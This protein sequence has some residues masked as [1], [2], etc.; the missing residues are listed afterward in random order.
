MSSEKKVLHLFEGFGI[1]LEYMIVNKES[2]QVLPIADKLIYDE[3]GAY[4]SD[5]EFG[6]IA[7]S[8]ELVQ[9]VVELKTQEP[10]NTLHDLA[11]QFQEHVQKINGMLGK[12]DAMLLPTGAHPFMDP[13]TETVL[14]QHEY[15]AVYEAYNNLFDCRGH[16]WSNLQST[17]INLP[18]AND[19]EFAR[20]HAAIRLVLP[21]IPA[22]SASSP[23]L[24]G[25][26]TGLEDT[27]IEVYRHNQQ[28]IPSIA[29]KVIPEPVTSR[30]QYEA[31]ILQPIYADVAPYDPQGVL[32]DEFLNSR[33]AIA[34]FSR[35]AIEIRLIDIQECPQADIAIAQAVISVVKALAAEKWCSIQS[36]NQI[37]TTW[38]ADLLLQVIKTGQETVIE[39]SDYLS[40]FGWSSETACTVK[41]LWSQL[42]LEATDL[43]TSSIEILKQILTHG[44]LAK[45]IQNTLGGAPKEGAIL[46]LYQYLAACLQNGYLFIPDAYA[47]NFT[48]L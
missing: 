21:I 17:H 14:W 25:K 7:W 2:L 24:D 48:Y 23:I 39:N 34:R 31:D 12:Y 11:G 19:E 44:N 47:K 5:V 13:F 42:L 9:H 29:G 33:G 40:C 28:K 8:N 27:R 10:A 1:E 18:F 3:V 16:G 36:L 32:Q 6:K 4:V 15:S 22:L 41:E 45:R 26:L 35:N 38:L 37:P 43:D 46:Q 30:E 20:L